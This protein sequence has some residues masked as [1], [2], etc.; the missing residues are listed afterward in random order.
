MTSVISALSIN[1]GVPRKKNRSAEVVSPVV[2][3]TIVEMPLVTGRVH[4]SYNSVDQAS[5]VLRDRSDRLSRAWELLQTV[6]RISGKG[7][8]TVTV[9]PRS[10]H[11]EHDGE[12][13]AELERM[14]YPLFH[15]DHVTVRVEYARA[16][17]ML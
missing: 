10:V 15:D 9:T 17:G 4:R 16:W 6:Q 5:L 12:A 7:D 1:R 2:W 14:L 8:W 13:F 3:R 11:L